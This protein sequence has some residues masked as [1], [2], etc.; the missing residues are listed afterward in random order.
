M[1]GGGGVQAPKQTPKSTHLHRVASSKHMQH[2]PRNVMLRSVVFAV[3][4]TNIQPLSCIMQN[5]LKERELGMHRVASN[6]GQKNDNSI[7]HWALLYHDLCI[8]TF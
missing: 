8:K 4:N 5:K 1:S 6:D 3:C 7:K 2:A